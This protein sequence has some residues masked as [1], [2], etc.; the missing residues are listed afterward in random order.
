MFEKIVLA[1]DGSEPAGR[2]LEAAANLAGCSGGE[3]VVVHVVERVAG[4]RGGPFEVEAPEEGRSILDE[5][6]RTLKERGVNVRGEVRHAFAG[7]VAK[8]ILDVVGA[9]H[10]DLVVMGTR[11]LSDWEGMLVGSTAH[12]ILH[13][14]SSP[15][16]VVR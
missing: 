10:A 12:K 16:L 3:I 15:V 6:V 7:R 9:E 14:G 2:A 5:A 11:G 8:E 4:G 1:V 13:L